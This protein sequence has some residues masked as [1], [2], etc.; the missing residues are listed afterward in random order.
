MSLESSSIRASISWHH[1]CQ[2]RGFL[3]SEQ[4]PDTI[5]IAPEKNSTKVFVEDKVSQSSKTT[6]YDL[7][8]LTD[9]LSQSVS[10][11]RIDAVIVSSVSG[12]LTLSPGASNPSSIFMGGTA[13]GI[14][15]PDGGVVLITGSSAIDSTHKNISITSGSSGCE[16]RI[17]LLG[18]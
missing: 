15:V 7:T 11:S 10:F 16:Y 14:T 8:S 6:N 13:P 3:N 18:G 12:D 4:G 2:N 1:Y 17:G 9:L 5:S